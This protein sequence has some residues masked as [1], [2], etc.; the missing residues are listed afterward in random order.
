VE[1]YYGKEL[2][3]KN[4]DVEKEQKEEQG[5]KGGGEGRRDLLYWTSDKG[6]ALELCI[7]CLER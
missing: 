2:E 4:D 1:G 6:A 7:A 3:V 5:E